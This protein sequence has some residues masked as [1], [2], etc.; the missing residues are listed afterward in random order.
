VARSPIF[1][2]HSSQS[3]TGADSLGAAGETPPLPSVEQF[4]RLCAPSPRTRAPIEISFSVDGLGKWK[5]ILIQVLF[6]LRLHHV[7]RPALVRIMYILSFAATEHIFLEMIRIR[8]A[9]SVAFPASDCSHGRLTCAAV[10]APARLRTKATTVRSQS[11]VYFGSF[12][13]RSGS[14]S[15]DMK[16]K[17]AENGPFLCPD[18]P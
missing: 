14:V 9:R 3:S 2:I 12:R 7:I 4:W 11:A 13:S 16:P 10:C 15:P 1:H 6:P 18:L 5:I 8:R 17:T